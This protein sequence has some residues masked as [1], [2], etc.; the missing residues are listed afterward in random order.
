MVH[1]VRGRMLVSMWMEITGMSVSSAIV[2]SSSVTSMQ[3]SYLHTALCP[4]VKNSLQWKHCPFLRHWATS[5]G[6][7]RLMD[8]V[9]VAT[10]GEE[11]MEVAGAAPVAGPSGLV[12]AR[13]EEC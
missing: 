2:S 13:H 3:N 10:D 6:V 12:Q 7:S 8:D 1:S 11:A 5:V 4:F 9:G